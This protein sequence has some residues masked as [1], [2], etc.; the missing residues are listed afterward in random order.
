MIEQHLAE[1]IIAAILGART[2]SEEGKTAMLD[3]FSD[4]SISDADLE[5]MMMDFC[6]AEMALREKENE[7]LLKIQTENNVELEAERAKYMPIQDKE[8]AEARVE[9]EEIIQDYIGKMG[10]LEGELD[11]ALEAYK[12]NA[13]E[14][15]EMAKIRATLG[16]GGTGA[17]S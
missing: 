10:K 9:E 12:R 16:I 5:R 11:Q 8:M 7:N 1:K 6:D 2:L 14:S 13:H 17:E 15:D 4:E 3:K